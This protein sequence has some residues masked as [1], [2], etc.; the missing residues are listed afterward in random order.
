M[1]LNA[2][3]AL[4]MCPSLGKQDPLAVM[5][6]FKCIMIFMNTKYPILKSN[7]VFS[8]TESVAT[9]WICYDLLIFCTHGELQ[10][11]M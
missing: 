5:G 10:N 8:P 9:Y 4:P 2:V 7:T 3:I 6:K 11:S 1:R